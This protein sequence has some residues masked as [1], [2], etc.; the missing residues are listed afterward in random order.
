MALVVM[1]DPCEACVHRPQPCDDRAIVSLGP[2]I[3]VAPSVTAIAITVTVAVGPVGTSTYTGAVRVTVWRKA[4]WRGMRCVE[5]GGPGWVDRPRRGRCREIRVALSV[6]GKGLGVMS[7]GL[8]V[9]GVGL[10]AVSVGL[11]VIASCS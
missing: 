2:T 8:G 9:V 5:G 7:V 3:A 4:V 1:I 6:V 11:G 10:G